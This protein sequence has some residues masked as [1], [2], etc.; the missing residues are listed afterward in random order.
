MVIFLYGAVFVMGVCIAVI[1]TLLLIRKRLQKDSSLRYSVVDPKGIEVL[2]P[3]EIGGVK[4]W[5]H[6]RGRNRD[7]PVLLFL[8]G[9]PGFSHIGWYDEIQRP[10]EEYFT[11][12]QWDQR[13][14]GKSHLSEKQYS[15]TLTNE[16]L[17][18]DA[19]GVITYLK[20]TLNKDK[21]LLMGWS[22]GTYLGMQ[23]A[24]KRP[25]WVSGYI[26][27]GQMTQIME[28]FREEHA[29]LLNHAKTV[30]DNDLTERLISM[31]PHPDPENIMSSMLK[32]GPFLTE[33]LSKLGK[34]G[35]RHNTLVDWFGMVRLRI[36][37]SPHYSLLEVFRLSLFRHYL[38][39]KYVG[40]KPGHPFG[41]EFMKINLPD[42][43]GSKF[44]VPI[45][46]FTGAHNWH[47][48]YSRSDGWFKRIEAPY[49]KQVWF[50]NSA[51]FSQYDE[52]GKLLYE[53]VSTVLPK[54]ET[55]SGLVGPEDGLSKEVALD[56]TQDRSV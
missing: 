20:E 30:G 41:E 29:L 11:V 35:L 44:E 24:K 36:L 3:V 28:D 7:N 34:R 5:L 1:A 6:I 27:V 37:I 39:A 12:V 14:S 52:A 25:E 21:V 13:F 19:E 10:W 2:K 32:Y 46:F 15:H 22:Y 50:D 8:H 38:G 23:L 26:G 42:E 56:V 43:L 40:F 48:P 49:K 33:K 17:L 9:G 55:A 31:M 47:L 54:I 18:A 51:H 45:F 16:Q 53:L 4:Q